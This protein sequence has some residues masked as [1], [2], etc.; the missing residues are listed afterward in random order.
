MRKRTEILI[1]LLSHAFIHFV[2]VK[3]AASAKEKLDNFE[4][5]GMLYRYKSCKKLNGLIF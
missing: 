1:E 5:D 3:D 4:Y 2:S